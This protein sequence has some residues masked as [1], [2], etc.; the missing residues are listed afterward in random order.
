VLITHRTSAISATTKLL[1]LR[2]GGAA[3]FGPTREVLNA[4][5]EANQKQLQTQQANQQANQQARAQ[6]QAQTDAQARAAAG[7]PPVPA[8]PTTDDAATAQEQ[9]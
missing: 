5:N 1:V 9:K 2:D 3:M 8:A 6:A 4:L 7:V